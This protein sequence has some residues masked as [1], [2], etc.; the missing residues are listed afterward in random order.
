[1]KRQLKRTTAVLLTSVILAAGAAS[2]AAAYSRVDSRN[3]YTE[4]YDDGSRMSYDAREE[5]YTFHYSDGTF[6]RT[7]SEDYD[8]GDV[9]SA[10]W[11]YSGGKATA[12]WKTDY[13][14]VAVFTLTIRCDGDIIDRPTMC[15]RG[16][17]D[18]SRL[19]LTAG[20]TGNYQF[21]VDA[22][23]P[24]GY[25]DSADSDLFAVDGEKL[26]AIRKR[27]EGGSNG[28]TGRS[29]GPGVQPETWQNVS[30]YWKYVKAD[31]NYAAGGWE[32]IGGKWYYF[33]NSGKMAA[34][35]WIRSAADPHVWYYVGPDGDMQTDRYIG[36]W[37]VNAA[38]EYRE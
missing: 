13:G 16:S 37:Y 11:S 28:G 14:H 21:H 15:G 24:G 23:W 29:G 18:L 6:F 2:P 3:G 1:M 5:S 10:G 38:G 9:K 12:W 7:F 19:I 20:R 32:S 17:V 8:E 31:G 25:T 33:D 26:D 4:Y 27:Q 35:Q 34:D 22:R 36:Q 30:G